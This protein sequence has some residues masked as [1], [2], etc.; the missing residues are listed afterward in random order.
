LIA[1]IAL[2]PVV[3]WL[4]RQPLVGRVRLSVTTVGA[5]AWGPLLALAWRQGGSREGL[6]LSSVAILLMVAS[7]SVR[8]P[9][10]LVRLVDVPALGSTPTA[11]FVD[12]YDESTGDMVGGVMV[13]DV[14]RYPPSPEG[15]RFRAR[16]VER[17]LS[18]GDVAR[19]FGCTVVDASDLER[20]G[21]RPEDWA[22]AFAALEKVA[23][24]RRCGGG[25]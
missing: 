1:L 17:G 25:E 21:K 14:H 24:S 11:G 20:G 9:R 7:D 18:L 15:K 5:V 6:V 4:V 8:A 10:V 19:A 3:L 2:L 23:P 22:A 16:R 13:M 12:H